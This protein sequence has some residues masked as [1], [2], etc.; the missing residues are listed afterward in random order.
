MSGAGIAGCCYQ[1]PPSA[2]HSP[3]LQRPANMTPPSEM[4]VP[5]ERFALTRPASRAPL[6]MPPT[7][8]SAPIGDTTDADEPGCPA[9][10]QLDTAVDTPIGPSVRS[11]Q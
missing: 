1:P 6:P 2:V 8:I 4:A 10:R 3:A 9:S 7:L 11:G 5:A